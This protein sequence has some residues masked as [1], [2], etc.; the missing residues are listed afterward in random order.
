MIL[1]EASPDAYRERG[2][3]VIPEVRKESW[4]HPAIANGR[5]L[6]REQ[7]RLYAYDITTEEGQARPA[8]GTR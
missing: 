3:F 8:G 7:G 5:L 4:A 2:T 1:V 6:L